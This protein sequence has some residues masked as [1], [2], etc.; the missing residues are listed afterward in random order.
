MISLYNTF[1]LNYQ[2][3][4]Y[5]C[6]IYYYHICPRLR[7]LGCTKDHED[8][9]Q[10]QIIFLLLYHT[11]QTYRLLL[12]FIVTITN[13]PVRYSRLLTDV[14]I[15]CTEYYILRYGF[16]LPPYL[17]RSDH[18]A[19]RRGVPD[20]TDIFDNLQ[21]F[22]FLFILTVTMFSITQPLDKLVQ[23]QEIDKLQCVV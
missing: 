6:W 23:A 10:K 15:R 18:E 8:M 12:N 19:H 2:V 21:I 3:I 22:S 17:T 1:L 7:P 13:I 4:N 11:I 14:M 9:A 20:Q 5:A 16:P